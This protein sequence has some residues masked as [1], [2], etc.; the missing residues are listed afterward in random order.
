MGASL[1]DTTTVPLITMSGISAT[2]TPSSSTFLRGDGVWGSP[3]GAGTV[4]SI[5]MTG[6]GV[7]FNTSITG[8]PITSNGT[9]VPALLAQTANTVFA[10]PTSAG[11]TAPTFRSLVAA[12]IPT[13]NQNTTGSAA[14]LSISG[15]TALL[16]FTGL[17]ST[18]RIKT[19]RDAAD[20]ILELGGSYTPTGTWTSMT[21]VTPALGTPA[22]GALTNCT[23]IPAAS[24]T[25]AVPA[26][27]DR[28]GIHNHNTSA[29]SQV[30][31]A[32]TFYY[33]AGSALTM[34]AAY[35][36][37]IGAGTTLKWRVA[38]TKTAA[39]TV[40]FDIVIYMGLNG[41]TADSAKV[42]QS[43][44]V[45]TAAVD[46]M[47]VDVMVVF[48]SS[49]AFYWTICPINKA[50][51]ATGF[52]VATGAGAFTSGTVSGLTTTTGSLI[53]GLGFNSTT[54]TP[55]VVIP[56]VEAHAEGVN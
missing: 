47:I 13:L 35:T 33:I 30:T 55:T 3:A 27:A 1:G 26:A 12:D 52:G 46:D 41:T 51:T 2:G 16:T 54:G 5:A 31:V 34:P 15:Q 53:F 17:A 29:Q 25:G 44:G 20:T 48:T 49:T 14:S 45:Q 4:T 36:T 28:N 21:L 32:N 8:S 9:L 56:M 6:D 42:T 50:V 39:G 19:T 24:L 10:G 7:V 43:V 38:L 18:N 37:A 11:P 40:A 23:S 22:S